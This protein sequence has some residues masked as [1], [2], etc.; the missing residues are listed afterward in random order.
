MNSKDIKEQLDE[1]KQLL[2]K[3]EHKEK[4]RKGVLKYG[5]FCLLSFFEYDENDKLVEDGQP[6]VFFMP[7][8]QDNPVPMKECYLDWYTNYFADLETVSSVGKIKAKK[9]SKEEAFNYL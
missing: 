7:W 9:I 3:T 6:I 8:G 2:L 4:S 1:L 5:E